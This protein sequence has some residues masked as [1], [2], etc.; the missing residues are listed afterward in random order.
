MFIGDQNKGRVIPKS[1]FGM[2]VNNALPQNKHPYNS[3]ECPLF[4][5]LGYGLIRFWDA[6]VV[7]RLVNTANGVYDWV[8]LDY[9]VNAAISAGLE[10]I[11]TFGA[12][13]DWATSTPGPY[14]NYNPNPVTNINYLSTFATEVANRY[15]GKIKYYEIYNEVDSAGSWV[16]SLSVM[17]QYGEAIYNAVKAQDSAAIVL[18]PN[19]IS[20]GSLNALTGMGY[21]REYLK[22]ASSYCDAIAMHLYTDPSQ[23]ESYIGLSKAY[24]NL[25]KSF[26]K[27]SVMCTETGVLKYFS[28]TG[29]KKEPRFDGASSIMSESQ[30]ASWVARM[31]I[32]GWLGGLDGLCYYL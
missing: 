16:G 31:L 21:L 32:C 8:A 24:L 22:L 23:P 15:R 13:P 4:A 3:V 30:G 2:H 19:T 11:Y 1:Y 7:H 5:D 9:R 18:S 29:E 12:P 25:A 10:I 27:Q 6:Y 28:A 14:P 17:A 26:G 20:W